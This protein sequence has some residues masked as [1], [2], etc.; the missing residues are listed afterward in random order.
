M[1]GRNTLI[2]GAVIFGIVAVT[3]KFGADRENWAHK[4][5]PG[6]W[7]PSRRYVKHPEDGHAKG[8]DFAPR[9]PV[10]DGIEKAN[11]YL[12]IAGRSN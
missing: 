10:W 4:P 7:Y 8:G 9:R 6:E 12:S 1:S 5:Q 2:A 3:W 11:L